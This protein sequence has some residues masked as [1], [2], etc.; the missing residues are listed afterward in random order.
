MGG[1]I[2]LSMIFAGSVRVGQWW[3]Y[4]N[5]V[6]PFYRLYYI[7]GGS[8]C[9]WINGEK[10]LL[11]EGDL[12]LTPK[13]AVH[14]Y[15]CD[16][17]M[18]VLYVC[19]FDDIAGGGGIPDPGQLRL[20]VEAAEIDRMLFRRYIELNPGR[21]LSVYNPR[22]YNDRSLYERRRRAA[23][24]LHAAE[25]ESS[26]ILLQLFSRFVTAGSLQAPSQPH[27]RSRYEWI[28]R[29][30]ISNLDRRLSVASLAEMIA[31]TPDHFSR[32]FKKVVGVG[33]N[34][35]IRLKRVEYAKSMLATSDI[36]VSQVGEAVGVSN[37][38]QFARLFAEVAGCS[39]TEYRRQALTGSSDG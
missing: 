12:F 17:S 7:E 38:A 36:P 20:R 27:V 1:A 19:F 18:D 5:V 6:S 4:K 23:S 13:F 35:Y 34:E 31:Q 16:N 39:P 3:R 11:A 14:S 15:E 28:V 2:T 37:P 33:P 29:Y 32:Q 26:G 8:G 25:M 24:P 30:I 21:S 10:H 9:V 22:H